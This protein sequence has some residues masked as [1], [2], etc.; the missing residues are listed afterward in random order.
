MSASKASVPT[1]SGRQAMRVMTMV[2][3]AV[4][5]GLLQTGCGMNPDYIEGGE[6]DVFLRVLSINDGAALSSDVRTGDAGNTVVEDDVSV[7]LG[8]RSKNPNV[9]EL[10]VARAIFLERYG[11]RY[12]RSDGRNTQGVDVPYDISG[13]LTGV[14]DLGENRLVSIEVVRS[15]AKLEPPLTNLKGI[16]PNALGGGPL[17]LTIFA[18]ITIYGRQTSGEAVRASG[19]LQIDFA[20]VAQ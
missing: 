3:A 16:V 4:L 5:G 19:T 2:T 9:T 17:I 7:D 10:Q 15:Q 12:F 6:G 1:G 18:E 14:V 20:D 8:N 11:V 13:P